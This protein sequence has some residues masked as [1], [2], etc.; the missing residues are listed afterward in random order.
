M[1][2]FR[3]AT[4]ALMAADSGTGKS[5]AILETRRLDDEA[6]QDWRRQQ[7]EPPDWRMPNCA[8]NAEQETGE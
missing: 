4:N 6:D 8:N 2:K 7:Y 3:P 5:L 1:R